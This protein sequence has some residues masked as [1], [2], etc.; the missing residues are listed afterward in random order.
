MKKLL[1]VLFLIGLAVWATWDN[2]E[3]QALKEQRVQ[4][5]EEN[6]APYSGNK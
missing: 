6:I 4:Q 2:E 5:I 1:I 3:K